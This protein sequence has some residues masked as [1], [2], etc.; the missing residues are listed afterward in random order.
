MKQ[1]KQRKCPA[2]E[3]ANMSSKLNKKS[4]KGLKQVQADRTAI[5][6]S[7][8][9]RISTDI[10]HSDSQ[11]GDQ[12]AI[13]KSL[14]LRLVG[15]IGTIKELQNNTKSLEFQNKELSCTNIRL[16]SKLKA[17]EKASQ[18]RIDLKED[19]HVDFLTKEIDDL[20][21]WYIFY[22]RI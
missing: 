6:E 13:I 12:D 17:A 1:M 8:S 16:Q 5:D 22:Y 10:M 15:A 4:K 19:S 7:K 14:H 2:Q 9:G 20:K 18:A 11:H 3:N 21:V